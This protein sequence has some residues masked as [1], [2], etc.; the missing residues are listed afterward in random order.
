MMRIKMFVKYTWYVYRQTSSISRTKS[1][2]NQCFSPRLAV[3]RNIQCASVV[4]QR[5]MYKTTFDKPRHNTSKQESRTKS[6]GVIYITFRHCE[7]NH[8]PSLDCC[9]YCV[10]TESK[11]TTC[12]DR[13]NHDNRNYYTCHVSS[14]DEYNSIVLSKHRCNWYYI[15]ETRLLLDWV[16]DTPSLQITTC[17]VI[18]WYMRVN[19]F[20]RI[21]FCII[22]GHV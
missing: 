5:F 8:L 3:V 20:I 1:Q 7:L 4:T 12:Q 16:N 9:L 18:I 6:Q 19:R 2:D 17:I 11:P 10:T 15:S 14:S 13:Y 22:N 21:G